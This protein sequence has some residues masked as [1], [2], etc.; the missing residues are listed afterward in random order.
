MRTT[1]KIT[2]PAKEEEVLDAVFCDLCGSQKLSRRLWPNGLVHN[3]IYNTTVQMEDG[4]TTHDSGEH[5]VTSFDI[6]CTCFKEKLMPW[7]IEQ[8]ARPT[9]E[10]VDW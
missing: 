6:C 1:K 2:I 4:Y 10:V 7:A 9:G 8:G 5:L 3:N